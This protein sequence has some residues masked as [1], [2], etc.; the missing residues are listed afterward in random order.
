MHTKNNKNY[1]WLTVITISLI[2]ATIN[3]FH[4]IIGLA[5]TAVGYTYLAT[6]HYYLDYFEY[7]QYIGAGIAGRWLPIYYFTTD[8][9]LADWRYYP[10]IL[11]GKIAWIFH[12]SP[13]VAYWVSVFI[14]TALT[15]IVFYYLINKMI[16]KEAFSLKIIAF[17][18][19]VFSGPVYKIL[20]N[21]G[22]LALSP[23][24]FWYGPSSFIRRFE[25]VPY[26]TL[27][28]LLILLIIILINKTWENLSHLTNK[29]MFINGFLAAI[30]IILVMTFSPFPLASLIPSLLILSAISFFKVKNNRLKILIFNSIILM[31]IIPFYFILRRS[32][33]Y[34]G[35]SF[36]VKWIVQPNWQFVLL[37]LGPIILF[38][39]FGI[40]EYLKTDNFLRK[41]LLIF[42]L[43]SYC[44]F[45]S[46][47]AYYMGT[48]N[49]R[50]LSSISY[51]CYG[52]LTVL[53]I[54][55]IS[56][57]FKK[58]KKTAIILISAL[59]IFYSCF[60]TFY[61]INIRAA[62]LDFSTPVTIWTY[63]PSPII[64]GLQSL[65]NYPEANV[66]TGP[67]G[68]IGMF[69][70]IFSYKR[71]YIGHPVRTNNIEKKRSIAY[72]FY[73]GQMT[74]NEANKFLKTNKIGFVIL[75]S[76]DNFDV[77]IINRYSFLKSI[78][79]KPTI[80]IWKVTN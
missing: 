64:E 31:L 21:N 11:L 74:E 23:Y 7:L 6:G 58:Y 50:F 30:L 33:G 79:V 51:I 10:Y 4:I 1:Q 22:Q 36:E 70:P 55:K 2:V 68:E 60:L 56:S 54:K 39:P 20:I 34:E 29:S 41:I 76:L 14:L 35:M 42:T 49:L 80:I 13:V 43:V 71:A 48:H 44:L 26:H 40:F 73:S 57:L 75:T 69:V 15:L 32:F 19:A 45:M 17:L 5:K 61:S 25:V 66:L 12:L 53:G 47:I 67:Y 77:N 18:T 63:L 27:G 52:V 38:F 62:G 16:P 72:L 9:N 28:L 3:I 46:P 8:I 59:L 65:H 78:F 37:N 24:D